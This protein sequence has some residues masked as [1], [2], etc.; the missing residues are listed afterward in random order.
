[1]NQGVVSSPIS[2]N[3]PIY[4]VGPTTLTQRL[5]SVGVNQSLISP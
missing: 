2:L 1:M 4:V 5:V 3:I